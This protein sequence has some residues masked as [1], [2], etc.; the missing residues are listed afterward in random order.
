MKL[1][2][3][4]TL[5]SVESVSFRYPSG[6]LALNEC[7][8]ALHRG[9]RNALIGPNGSG[10][11]TLFQH[12]NGLLRPRA[13]VV[14]Y[15]GRALEYSRSGLRELRSKVGMVFQ[16]PDRQLL[17]ASVQEDVA[18]GPLNLD[19]PP[20]RVRDRV[21]TALRAVQMHDFA[22]HPVH[23]LSF[24]QKKRI[25]IA[26]VLAM[27]P[28]LLILDEPMAGLDHQMQQE[29]LQVLDDLHAEGLTMLL[30]TH[31]LEFA[32]RWADR[33]H[34]MVRGHCVA[35]LEATNLAGHLSELSSVGLPQPTILSIHL[36]LVARGLLPMLPAP[37]RPRNAA[38]LL[39]LLATHGRPNS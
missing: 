3:S 30:A 11:T 37:D 1:E 20:D 26:G 35:S 33:I 25:C 16:N 27:E 15:G 4:D 22:D 10:K 39:T 9:S 31:D 14:R 32:Y 2:H 5:L 6:D 28:E 34:L 29:F 12:L 23:H 17:S 8:L 7:S 24:G 19:L 18:F 21:G 13:G 38:Q 36:G